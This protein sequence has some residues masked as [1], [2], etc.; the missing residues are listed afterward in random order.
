M[1]LNGTSSAHSENVTHWHKIIISASG[2]IVTIVQGLIA[3]II[4]KKRPW[5][6][7]IYPFL[8]TAFYM[9]FLAGLMNVINLNDEG[10]IGASLEI[11]TFTLPLIVSGLIFF[12]V[13]GI[14]KKYNLSWKFQLWTTLMVMV[15]SSILILFDQFFGIRII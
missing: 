7:Y 4:L 8:F 1:R 15:A 11:G 14:S 10:R 2:P 3:Y 6:K 13:Y 12:M 5:N 9:R